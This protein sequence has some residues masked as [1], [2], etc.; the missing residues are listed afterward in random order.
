MDPA[1][2]VETRFL[3]GEINGRKVDLSFDI[4]ENPDYSNGLKLIR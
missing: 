2:I 1:T 3:N 4:S